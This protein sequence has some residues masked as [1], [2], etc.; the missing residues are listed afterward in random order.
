[1]SG[2]SV[3]EDFS[4]LQQCASAHQAHCSET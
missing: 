3:V 4:Q 2:E 1:M